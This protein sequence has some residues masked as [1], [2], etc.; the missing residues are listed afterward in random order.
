MANFALIYMNNDMTTPILPYTP[1][2]KERGLKSCIAEGW[3][4][5]ALRFRTFMKPLWFP[6]LLAGVGGAF[7]VSVALRLCLQ[8]LLPARVY[9]A[10]G[11]DA[12][13]AKMFFMPDILSLLL[14]FVAMSAMFLGFSIARGAVYAQILHYVEADALPKAGW[15]L[16]TDVLRKAS[17]RV[18]L[19]SAMSWIA[20]LL[21]GGIVLWASLRFSLWLLLLLIPIF[22]IRSVYSAIGEQFYLLRGLSLLDAIRA[23]FTHEGF[24]GGY[25]PLLLLMFV[26]MAFLCVSALLPSSI[27]LFSYFTNEMG[28]LLGDISGMPRY[29]DLLL[30]LLTVIGFS[31]SLI[32]MVLRTW[33]LAFR[34]ARYLQ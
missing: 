28:V 34:T 2:R 27:L 14:L 26:P 1:F 21:L 22:V 19:F 32:G 30:P 13:V 16:P 18:L 4:L 24:S 6:L 15:F 10:A 17:G 9:M 5:L 12:E 20:A 7:F 23:S 33:V 31:V 25:F 29:L 3:K 11:L 8:T